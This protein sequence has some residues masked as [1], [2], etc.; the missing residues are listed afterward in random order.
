MGTSGGGC[1]AEEAAQ[2]RSVQDLDM[3][4]HRGSSGVLGGR[5]KGSK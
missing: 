4:V 2:L 1:I 5:H 3:L